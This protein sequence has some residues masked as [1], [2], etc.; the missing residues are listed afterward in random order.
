MSFERAF[1][2]DIKRFVCRHLLASYIMYTHYVQFI[3]L[4]LVCNNSEDEVRFITMPKA[5]VCPPCC[6]IIMRLYVVRKSLAF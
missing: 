4:L 2:S 3:V 6:F 1:L 5:S